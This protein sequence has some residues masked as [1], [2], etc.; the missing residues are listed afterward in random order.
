MQVHGFPK[1]MGVLTHLDSFKDNGRLKKTKKVL[2][3]RFWAEIYQGRPSRMLPSSHVLTEYEIESGSSSIALFHRRGKRIWTA[4]ALVAFA[5][6][7][8]G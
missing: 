6:Q 5:E 4:F 2:K 1:V 3:H 8:G 7:H